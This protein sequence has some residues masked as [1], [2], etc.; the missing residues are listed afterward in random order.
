MRA[1]V[2]ERLTQNLSGCGIREMA[3]PCAG[4]GEVLVRIEAASLAFPDLLMAQGGYQL[5][6]SLPFVLGTDI[7]GTVVSVGGAN[8]R[9]K[10]GDSVMATRATGGL[11]QFGIYAEETLHHKPESLSFEQA[12]SL[13]SAY[14]TAYVALVRG[15]A[16]QPGEWLLVHGCAGGSVSPLSIWARHLVHESLPHPHPR[17]SSLRFRGCFSPKR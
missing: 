17:T 9:W 14:L 1:L 5:K 3:I 15:A 7:A 2:A 6:P 12:A 4:P 11:A 16:I 10:V 8:S 13:G